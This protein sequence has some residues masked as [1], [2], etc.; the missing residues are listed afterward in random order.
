V[1]VVTDQV[2]FVRPGDAEPLALTEVPPLVFSE[3]MRDVDLF[4]GVTSVGNDLRVSFVKLV[5]LVGG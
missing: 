1:H 4:V 3:L 5:P 2:R